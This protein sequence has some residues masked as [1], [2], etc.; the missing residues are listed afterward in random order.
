VKE[1]IRELTLAKATGDA[2][3]KK[4]AEEAVAFISN[5]QL[6]APGKPWH[7]GMVQAMG[8]NNGKY[9]GPDFEGQVDSGMARETAWHPLKD[10]CWIKRTDEAVTMRL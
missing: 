1:I 3:Y 2:L 6:H 4:M 7:G 9:W 8:Q 5:W 10:G